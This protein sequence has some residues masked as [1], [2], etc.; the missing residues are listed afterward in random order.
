MIL[1]TGGWA[2]GAIFLTVGAVF[3]AL[4]ADR[5][6]LTADVCSRLV[7]QTKTTAAPTAKP[8]TKNTAASHFL[9]RGF[10][11]GF[12]RG[13]GWF[14][15]FISC[16]TENVERPDEVHGPLDLIV[17]FLRVGLFVLRFLVLAG[18]SVVRPFFGLFFFA[19]GRFRRGRGFGRRRRGWLRATVEYNK[20]Y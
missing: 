11:L 10:G 2:V 1:A 15:G 6:P 4:T 9:G 8:V 16:Q 5:S 18:F 17:E 13:F 19:S 3:F 12:D 7:G 14:D 20:N